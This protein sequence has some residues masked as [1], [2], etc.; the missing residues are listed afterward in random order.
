MRIGKTSAKGDVCISANAVR[1]IAAQGDQAGTLADAW[2]AAELIVTQRRGI[3]ISKDVNI[4]FSH[5]EPIIQINGPAAILTEPLVSGNQ[6]RETCAASAARTFARA[7][8]FLPRQDA[9][10][11]FANFDERN[12]AIVAG[13]QFSRLLDRFDLQTIRAG[14]RRDQGNDH[15]VSSS[16]FSAMIESV[17]RDGA[18][19]FGVDPRQPHGDFDTGQSTGPELK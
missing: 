10:T 3:Q 11:A 16:D 12:L 4:E 14:L 1:V 5:F 18:F 19:S 7:A 15:A 9:A 13:D 6:D 17:G 8:S 2:Q